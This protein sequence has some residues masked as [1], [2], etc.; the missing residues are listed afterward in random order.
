MTARHKATPISVTTP[1]L[2]SSA[3]DL[4]KRC[5]IGHSYQPCRQG[6][7]GET[8]RRPIRTP[9]SDN[10]PLSHRRNRRQRRGITLRIL[11]GHR[12]ATRPGAHGGRARHPTPH[13]DLG[14]LIRPIVEGEEPARSTAALSPIAA[15]QVSAGGDRIRQRDH[16]LRRY[17]CG[18]A[19]ASGVMGKFAVVR[20]AGFHSRCECQPRCTESQIQHFAAACSVGPDGGRCALMLRCASPGRLGQSRYARGCLAGALPLSARSAG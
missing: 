19:S 9:G 18:D 7:D 15:K 20:A 4:L 3:A 10:N 14:Q 12:P 16:W 11:Q 13:L 5:P 17:G 8:G 1:P 2:F 6:S